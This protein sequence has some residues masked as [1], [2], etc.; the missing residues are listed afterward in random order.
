MTI[1]SQFSFRNIVLVVALL[2]TTGRAA[3]YYVDAT[4]GNDAN[5]GTSSD[6]AWKTLAKVSART[7]AAG[8]LILLK[9]GE[10]WT[11]ELDL[12]GDGTAADPIVVDQYG[13]GNKPFIN[14]GGYESAIRLQGVSYWEVNNLEIINDG[15]A[16]LTGATNYRVG[17]IVKTTVSVVRSHIY[18]RHLNIHNIFPE[19]GPEGHGIHVIATGS[20]TVNTYYDDVRVE[21]CQ[22]SLT[23]HYGVWMQ[24]TGSSLNP[25]YEFN[26]NLI[27]RSNTF[28]NTGGSGAETGFA[29]GVLIANNVVDHSGASVDSRQWARGS[30]YWPFQ[31]DNVLVLSNQFLHARGIGDSCG[32]HI[33]YGNSNVTVQYNLSLDNEGGF[34]EILGGCVN[35]IYRYNVSVNDGARVKGVNGAAQDG[36]L[37]WVSDYYGA[38]TIGSTNSQIYNNTIYV[39]PTITNSFLIVQKSVDTF[40]QNNIFYLAGGTIYTNAGSNTI[41]QNN[42][43]YGNLPAGLP[44][45]PGAVFANPVLANAGG[46]NAADYQLLRG[47]PAWTTGTNISSN[48][49][50]DYWGNAI[51]AAAPSIGTHEPGFS[52][53]A[54]ISVNFTETATDLQQIDANETFGIASRGSVV[55]GWT[56]LYRTMI[57]SSLPF[58][59][60]T[61]GTVSLTGTAPGGWSSF[62][63]AYTNT[64]LRAGA[65]DYTG[66]VSPTAITLTNLAANFP[67]GYQVIVYLGGFNLCSNAAIS[68]G[69]TTYYFQPLKSPVAPVNF[70]QT[71]TTSNPGNVNAPFA[72]YAVFG[73][74]TL[75]TSDKLTLTLEVL[76]GS[77]AGLCG[78]QILPPPTRTAMGVPYVWFAGYGIATNDLADTD[79]DGM[80]AW[81]E[82]YAGTI[83]TNGISRFRV[84]SAG[85][86]NEHFALSWLGG[87]NGYSGNWSMA[88]STNLASTNWTTI[89]SKTIPRDPS[90]TNFWTDPAIKIG[91]QTKFYRPC[92]EYP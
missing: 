10:S 68:D 48:G 56:N 84:L 77:G 54:I 11:G 58:S 66:T 1:K 57:A 82:Y 92:I 26:Q 62:N 33:D 73:E 83:P 50:F 79:L 2:A 31:C 21:D 9:A 5:S 71:T 87:T 91:S 8:D 61:T 35:A 76:Y 14:G 44:F 12:N 75:L 29:D 88:V 53:T 72:Q 18:L 16:T 28:T 80:T 70:L 32:V 60:G 38:Q 6:A 55:G 42:L 89:A 90:G 47:S 15:G 36:H 63:I 3:T 22:I 20:S 34:V 52:T 39:G 13:T 51:P 67:E 78:F 43:W 37:I 81:Q 25:G 40:I 49:G 59:D 7:F 45:G 69:T 46:T 64:P 86:T 74:S 23:G 4:G 85:I 17:V 19:T 65:T 41:F 24:H 27:I 30:G